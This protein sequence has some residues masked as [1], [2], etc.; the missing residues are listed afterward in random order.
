M[1]KRQNTRTIQTP[2][3]QGEDSF[4]VMRR[5]T[6][7]EVR[8]LRKKARTITKDDDQVEVS[9]EI[10]SD[11]LADC[12][13]KWNWVDDNGEPLPQPHHNVDVF[14]ILTDEEFGFLGDTLLGTGDTQ[15]N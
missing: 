13:L 6:V 9:I 4:V 1:P 2:D 11:T 7:G 8:A 12:V 5:L 3:L 10:S 14:D 15:K